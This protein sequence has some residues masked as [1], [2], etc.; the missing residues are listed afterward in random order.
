MRR[1]SDRGAV[2]DPDGGF[3]PIVSNQVFSDNPPLHP[4]AWRILTRQMTP[5]N[6]SRFIPLAER[7]CAEIL[8]D[9]G[10][11]GSFDPCADFAQRLAARFWGALDRPRP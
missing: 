6:V 7:L 11:R 8:A 3:F 10:G 1:A 2:V 4:E 9:L 5:R